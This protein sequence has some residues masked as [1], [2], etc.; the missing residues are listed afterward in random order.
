MYNNYF[1]E[2]FEGYDEMQ[3]ETDDEGNVTVED[4]RPRRAVRR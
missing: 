3:G 2:R 4:P 1:F